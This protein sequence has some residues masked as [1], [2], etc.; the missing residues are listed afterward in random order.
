MNVLTLS[1]T[2]KQNVA[3]DWLIAS[4]PD[5]P[6]F[7]EGNPDEPK[8]LVFRNC[9]TCSLLKIQ[10]QNDMINVQSDNISTLAI[11]KEV[12]SRESTKRRIYVSDSVE[13]KVSER[14][15]RAFWKTRAMN[16]AK[17]LQT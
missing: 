5:I 4:L 2:F 17:W 14:S 15:E 7:Q 11:F 8:I 10:Y 9:F 12:V 16:P 13:V 3:H 1:G 6:P